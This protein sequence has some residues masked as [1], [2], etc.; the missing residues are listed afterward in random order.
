MSILFRDIIV[1]EAP[2]NGSKQIMSL[3]QLKF[4][5]KPENRCQKTMQVGQGG[6]LIQNQS[7]LWFDIPV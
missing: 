2:Q 5:T 3:N 7:E 4:T 1:R 6:M